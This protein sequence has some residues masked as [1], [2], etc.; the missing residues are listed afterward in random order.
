VYKLQDAVAKIANV[1]RSVRKMFLV[2]I[3]TAAKA[4]PTLTRNEDKAEFRILNSA[5]ARV[6]TSEFKIAVPT[7]LTPFFLALLFSLSMNL[8]HF[9]KKGFVFTPELCRS[10][11][12]RNVAD[13]QVGVLPFSIP[14]L[15]CSTFG[16]PDRNPC[17]SSSK[18]HDG[19]GLPVLCRYC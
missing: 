4:Q 19:K 12:T 16:S 14:R 13:T 9:S 17:K 6:K 11:S 1:A 3:A 18:S 10:N 7:P 8:C 2:K 15:L 5:S